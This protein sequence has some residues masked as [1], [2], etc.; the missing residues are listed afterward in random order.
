[1]LLS[2][3]HYSLRLSFDLPLNTLQSESIEHIYLSLQ[4]T[5]DT[6]SFLLIN[7]L[8]YEGDYNVVRPEV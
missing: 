6:D 8:H 3:M 1:M 4:C 2:S 7:K 5:S